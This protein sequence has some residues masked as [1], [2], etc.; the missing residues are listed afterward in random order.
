MAI[1]AVGN[2]GDSFENSLGT[3]FYQQSTKDALARGGIAPTSSSRHALKL[4]S[5]VSEMW[6]HGWWSFISSQT[7]SSAPL[8]DTYDSGVGTTLFRILQVLDYTS[9]AFAYK[10]QYWNGSAYVD[11]ADFSL[12]AFTA[13]TNGFEFDI[14]FKSGS[15]GRFRVYVERQLVVDKSGSYVIGATWDR[16]RFSANSGLN[17]YYGSIIVADASTVGLRLDSLI[18]NATS[19]NS[20]WT[21]PTV[22]NLA[23]TTNAPAV[24]TSTLASTNTSGANFQLN[25]ENPASFAT[26]REA[27]GVSVA[28]CGIVQ[29]GSGFT[30]LSLYVNSTSL[31][32][33]SFGTSFTSYQQFLTTNPA[34]GVAWTNATISNMTIGAITS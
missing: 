19:S 24:N 30:N 15:S 10:A 12:P 17:V 26:H 14:H 20:G 29:A 18:P 7:S 31:G 32:N 6:V 34:T 22:A 21:N 25:Y 5:S 3:S 9:D 13:S 27:Q 16:V 11:I 33:M 23:D 8:I 2:E 1:L 4:S 28:S